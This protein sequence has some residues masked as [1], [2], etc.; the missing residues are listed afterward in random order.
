VHCCIALGLPVGA[1]NA[2]SNFADNL[3]IPFIVQSEFIA[4]QQAGQRLIAAGV[5]QGICLMQAA[6]I[7]SLQ[8][9]CDGMEYAFKTAG[10]VKFLGAFVVP[11]TASAFVQSVGV[12]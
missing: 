4:G 11:Q 9:R 10:N 5:K 3:G 6:N 7:T 1:I 2:G 8:S 12:P